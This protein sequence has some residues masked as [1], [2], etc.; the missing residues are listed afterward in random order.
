MC[1][2]RTVA[3]LLLVLAAATALPVF[4]SCSAGQEQE[5]GDFNTYTIRIDS[6]SV[7]RQYGPVQFEIGNTYLRQ[8]QYAEAVKAYT[9]AINNGYTR[10]EAYVNRA[11]AYLSLGLYSGAIGDASLSLDMSPSDVKSLEVRGLAY[12]KSGEYRKAYEDLSNAIKLA[13]GNK[14]DYYQRGMTCIELARFDESMSDFNKAVEIDANYADA[15]FGRALVSDKYFQDYA[16]ALK[17]YTK[18]VDL[19]GIGA[20]G[21]LNNRGMVYFKLNEYNIAIMDLSQLLEKAPD[22]WL[23]YYNRGSCY[24][25]IKQYQNAVNDY[26]TYLALDV[27]NKYGVVQSADFLASYYKPF[28]DGYTR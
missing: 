25:A 19:G 5:A 1:N 18:V 12:L 10:N 20:I 4:Q 9:T 24:A 23:A 13:P 15:Y 2:L 14:E 26:R 21:A 27:N 22:Y 8:K 28:L 11:G 6:D 7:G 3:M 17:D 16:A